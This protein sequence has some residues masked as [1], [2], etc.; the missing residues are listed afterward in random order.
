MNKVLVIGDS[1]EDVF[2]YGNIERICPEAP[3]PVF[4][5]TH[6][7]KNPGMAK[8]VVTNFNSL[9]VDADIITNDNALKT[10]NPL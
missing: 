10:Y 3:V 6:T 9:G 1:C 8:N 5:P 7:T 4:I 2:V